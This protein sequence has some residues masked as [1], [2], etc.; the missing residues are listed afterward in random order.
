MIRDL[1]KC[2]DYLGSFGQFW[3]LLTINNNAGRPYNLFPTWSLLNFINLPSY[4]KTI[5]SVIPLF[6]N[7]HTIHDPFCPRMLTWPP[8]AMKCYHVVDFISRDS[9]LGRRLVE[10]LRHAITWFLCLPSAVKNAWYVLIAFSRDMTWS[11][12]KLISWLHL[13]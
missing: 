6:T 4:K 5:S 13:D 10:D 7:F 1:W 12:V 11:C 2:A 9:R 8:L 3:Y